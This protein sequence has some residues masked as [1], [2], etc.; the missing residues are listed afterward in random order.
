M[1]LDATEN[2]PLSALRYFSNMLEGKN[3]KVL[4]MLLSTFSVKGTCSRDQI[5]ALKN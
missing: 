4:P 3:F 5:T 2:K 1:P